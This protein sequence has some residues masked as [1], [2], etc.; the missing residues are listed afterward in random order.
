MDKYNDDEIYMFNNERDKEMNIKQDAVAIELRRNKLEKIPDG[1]PAEVLHLDISDNHVREIDTSKFTKIQM[2][3]LGYNLLQNHDSIKNSTLTELYIMANDIR[4]V[5]KSLKYQTNLK[6]F[7]IA[8]NRLTNI[9]NLPCI[10][11]TIE[12][13]YL[14]AN[15]ISEFNLNLT[16]LKNLK[17][18]DLQFNNLTEFDCALLPESVEVLMLNNNKNLEKLLKPREFRWLKTE[19]TKLVKEE[20]K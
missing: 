10:S 1:V 14:G 20:V 2:L 13:I 17:V 15:K 11:E 18:V 7:D 3:D 5:S 19:D 6:K 8:F 12:E 9:D 4:Q 16:H